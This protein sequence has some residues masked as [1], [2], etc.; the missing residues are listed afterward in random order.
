MARMGMSVPLPLA[1]YFVCAQ[2]DDE[3]DRRRTLFAF[4]T[5][6]ASANRL[7]GEDVQPRPGCRRAFLAEDATY[8]RRP[9]IVLC[10]ERAVLGERGP[11]LLVDLPRARRLR[12]SRCP[13][14]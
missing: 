13:R 3:I 2:Q 5:S 4:G 7:L 8:E 10:G 6:R 9:P 11:G 12:R 1:G 14:A